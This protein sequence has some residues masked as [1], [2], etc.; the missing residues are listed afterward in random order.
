MEG[1]YT[2]CR[3]TDSI[4]HS[5]NR[6]Y[7]YPKA[8]HAFVFNS[9]VLELDVKDILKP[10]FRLAKLH[11][12]SKQALVLR[13]DEKTLVATFSLRGF[14]RPL[15]YSPWN[16]ASF[17]YPTTEDELHGWVIRNVSSLAVNPVPID[18]GKIYDSCFQ[19]T[20]H[21]GQCPCGML[22]TGDCFKETVHPR[23][24]PEFTPSVMQIDHGELPDKV[25]KTDEFKTVYGFEYV[26]PGV[27]TNKDFVKSHRAWDEI[28]FN[29]IDT[30]RM[31]FAQR[32]KDRKKLN[33]FRKENCAKC[34]FQKETYHS[35]RA[36]SVTDCGFISQ[37]S[38]PTTEEMAQATLAKWYYKIGF[39]SIEG[40]SPEQRDYLIRLSGQT[41]DVRYI[42]SNKRRTAVTFGYFQ[43]LRERGTWA[44][45]MVAG[46]G[47]RTREV[48]FDSYEELQEKITTLPEKPEPAALSY[49]EKLGC[50]IFGKRTYAYGGWGC[51]YPRHTVEVER[52]YIYSTLA[53]TR[54]VYKT[55]ALYHDDT[56]LLVWRALQ[57]YAGIPRYLRSH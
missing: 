21:A 35:S 30:R 56:N 55:Q 37:C 11:K 20:R 54:G 53:T 26:S 10:L 3:F 14:P 52:D 57:T 36:N 12:P 33:T 38:E 13:V 51:Q 45:T 50:A 41:R 24:P 6:S 27:T 46:A 16:E 8:P 49:Q 29:C 44:Y 18:I 47:D 42:F 19:L 39:D 43:F 15:K 4:G 1:Y 32:G 2:V 34:V 40:F 28:D 22:D 31:D 23:L 9:K 7:R 48:L 17:I 25:F 5:S